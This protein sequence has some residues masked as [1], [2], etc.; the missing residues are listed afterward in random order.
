[1]EHQAHVPEDEQSEDDA[2]DGE[3]GAIRTKELR[4]AIEKNGQADNEKSSER[5]KKAVAVRRDAGPIRIAGDEKIKGKE[6]RKERSAN[7][8]FAAPEKKEADDGKKKNGSPGEEAVIGRKENAEKNGGA[9]EPI[10]EGGVAGFERITVNDEA[11]DENRQKAEEDD[12]AEKKMI[13]EK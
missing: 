13:H 3:G 12:D 5:N 1:L 6:S 4:D 10:V 8:G 9:P 7:A 11:R 2:G